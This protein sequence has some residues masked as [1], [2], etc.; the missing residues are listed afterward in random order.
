MQMLLMML[1]ATALCYAG[2]AGLS[3]AMPRHYSQLN[4]AKLSASHTRL[5]LI[6]STMLLIVSLWPAI[7]MWGVVVGIVVWLGLLS[8][9]ALIWV[10]LLAYWPRFAATKALVLAL[11]GL[12]A[13][14]VLWLN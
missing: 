8:V 10:A 6:A 5:L 7:S 14:I 12:S 11:V 9:A 13:C 2:M 1:L 4:S 3:L